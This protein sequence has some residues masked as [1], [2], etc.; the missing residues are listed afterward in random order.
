MFPT[1]PA[2]YGVTFFL[3]LAVEHRGMYPSMR[4]ALSEPDFPGVAQRRPLCL[5]AYDANQAGRLRHEERAAL[6]PDDLNPIRE[7]RAAARER[8]G[9][10]DVLRVDGCSEA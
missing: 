7:K 2:W 8:S 3:R 10:N 5:L 1:T 9:R 4:G 6:L